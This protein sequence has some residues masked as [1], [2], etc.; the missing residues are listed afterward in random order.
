MAPEGTGFSRLRG[1]GGRLATKATLNGSHGHAPETPSMQAMIAAA[2]RGVSPGAAPE[3]PHN[4][5]VAPTILGL[6]GV[7]IPEWVEGEPLAL[8]PGAD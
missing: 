1:V 6:L 3:T 4:L 2:G 7:P 5:D 8:A